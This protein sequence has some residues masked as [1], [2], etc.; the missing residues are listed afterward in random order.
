MDFDFFSETC[1]DKFNLIFATLID[2]LENNRSF[3]VEVFF[4]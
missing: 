4:L 2:K 1:Q 3:Q